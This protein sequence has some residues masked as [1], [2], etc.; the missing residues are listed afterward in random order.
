ML[1]E[2]RAAMLQQQKLSSIPQARLCWLW[3]AARFGGY[4][5]AHSVYLRNRIHGP[6]G[7]S[8]HEALFG[9]KPRRDHLVPFGCAA[10]A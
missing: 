10:Y 7:I 8:P 5:S 6:D 2:E 3:I 9:R 4:A 1:E